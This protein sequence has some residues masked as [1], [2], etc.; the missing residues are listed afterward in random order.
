[1]P[2][3]GSAHVAEQVFEYLSDALEPEALAAFERHVAACAACAA[4][5][6]KQRKFLGAVRLAL[7]PRLSDRELLDKVRV[8]HARRMAAEAAAPDF[9]ARV[10]AWVESFWGGAVLGAASGAIVTAAVAL[11]VAIVV[12]P[13]QPEQ[14]GGFAP[15]PEPFVDAGV[16]PP[17]KKAKAIQSARCRV[18]G[19]DF[20]VLLASPSGA[21]DAG[22]LEL[23]FLQLGDAEATTAVVEERPSAFRFV[24]A[25]A[26]ASPAVCDQVAAAA[27]PEGRALVLVRASRGAQLDWLAA[28]VYDTR[29]REVI[30]WQILPEVYTEPLQI[31]ALGPEQ[32]PGFSVF[33][34]SFWSG[35]RPEG[36]P[37][38]MVES[39]LD[40][41]FDG[42]NVVTR[43]DHERGDLRR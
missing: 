8:E 17:L 34:V 39:W 35:D 12:W 15:L 2:E 18:E 37:R 41:T 16:K 24:P 38:G 4:E 19:A 1:M 25:V 23:R 6:E 28:A 9:S 14:L 5:V 13:A 40:L 43:W 26:G 3:Q 22:D 10:W 27:L 31:Q 42:K 29:A 21:P 36:E 33:A 30:A 20:Q 7:T 11:A 32:G